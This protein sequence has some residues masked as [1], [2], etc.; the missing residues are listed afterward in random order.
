[1]RLVDETRGST[2]RDLELRTLAGEYGVK[3]AVAKS[4]EQKKRLPL[5]QRKAEAAI[6]RAYQPEDF[7]LWLHRKNER[8]DTTH[9]RLE[10]L[11]KRRAASARI[12]RAQAVQPTRTIAQRPTFTPDELERYRAKQ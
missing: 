6:V 4:P 3:V 8:D 10:S 9:E 5:E 12:K 7:D 2:Q 11:S 1:M